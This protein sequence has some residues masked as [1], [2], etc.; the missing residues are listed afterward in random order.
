E[1]AGVLQCRGQRALVGGVFRGE[2]PR[3]QMARVGVDRE[4]EQEE[5]HQ[6]Q[7]YGQTDSRAIAAHLQRFLAQYRKQT[8]EREIVHASVSR[9]IWMNTSSRRGS[10]SCQVSSSPSSESI[11]LRSAARFVPATR[12]ARPNTAAVSTPGNWRRRRTA[13]SMPGPVASN[14]T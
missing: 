5:L 1:V 7:H 10:T 2:Q 6:R 13:V 8:G 9:S 4:A 14:V 3:W 11:E 12:R